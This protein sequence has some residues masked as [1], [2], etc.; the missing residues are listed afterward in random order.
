MSLFGH[1]AVKRGVLRP[2][3]PGAPSLFG[4][5]AVKR[6][7]FCS[8]HRCTNFFPLLV[9]SVWCRDDFL[10][11]WSFEGLDK[12]VV[13]LQN[14]TNCILERY[15]RHLNEKFP[16]R[17]PNILAFAESL[18][19]ESEHWISVLRDVSDGLESEGDYDKAVI[20]ELPSSYENF[21]NKKY[22]RIFVDGFRK[23]AGMAKK[24]FNK[25]AAAKTKKA[26]AATRV[27]KMD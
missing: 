11:V 5:D 27:A 13:N 14:K 12:E 24:A 22:K 21:D 23:K 7:V 8:C 2:A 25:K 15:N 10:A 6:G 9:L 18:Y 16:R 20:V 1:D 17:H 19:E 4:H 3:P 26:K